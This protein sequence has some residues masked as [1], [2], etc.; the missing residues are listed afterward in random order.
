MDGEW[1]LT[2]KEIQN[3]H[4]QQEAES[5]FVEKVAQSWMLALQDDGMP[6]NISCQI[7]EGKWLCHLKFQHGKEYNVYLDE[8][9]KLLN[10]YKKV[11]RD[12]TKTRKIKKPHIISFKEMLS[13]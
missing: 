12:I 4:T 2:D 3:L 11:I 6:A 7:E 8:K 13:L 5:L 9:F 10:F 1:G